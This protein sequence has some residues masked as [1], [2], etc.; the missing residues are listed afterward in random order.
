MLTTSASFDDRSLVA[1]VLD[2][3]FLGR[4]TLVLVVSEVRE[5]ADA[6]FLVGV[7]VRCVFA[8]RFVGFGEV[9]SFFDLV[10]FAV[11]LRVLALVVVDDFLVVL[12]LVCL[13]CLVLGVVDLVGRFGLAALDAFVVVCVLLVVRDLDVVVL[14]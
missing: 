10:S 7:L 5:L 9:V 6:A 4:R 1:G 11:T 14:R 2:E 8:A 13:S 12:A 3:V